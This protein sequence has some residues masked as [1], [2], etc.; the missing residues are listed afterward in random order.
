[1]ELHILAQRMQ[2]AKKAAARRGDLRL[3]LPIGYVYD[4]DGQVVVDPDQ[5]V[6]AAVAD[7]FRVFEETG[8]CCGVVKQFRDRK[9]P[10][11]G[12]AWTGEISWMRL[13][14]SQARAILRNPTYAGAYVSGRYKSERS[15]DTDG[16]ISTRTHELPADRWEVIIHD[17]HRGYISWDTYLG[18]TS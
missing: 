14:Q 13:R 10:S 15:I 6:E 17:H 12:Q 2:E 18:M 8:T 3:S 16:N 9:F 1:V 11:H 5:E 7:V 4:P